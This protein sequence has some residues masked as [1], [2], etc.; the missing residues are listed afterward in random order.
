MPFEKGKTPEGAKPFVEGQS[1]NPNGR[2]KGSRNRS[3]L[4]EKWLKVKI[5][6]PNLNTETG[7]KTFESLKDELNI[8]LEDAII[9]ALIQKAQ[10]GDVAAIKEIQDTLHGKIP[11]VNELTGKDG[12]AIQ[13]ESKVDLTK[14]SIDE[15]IEFKKML[16][17]VNG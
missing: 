13:T 11:N 12:G 15:L 1:G 7:I 10:S 16:E 14:L 17:K 2:P 5:K 9:L 3:T 6:V 4:V 8:T